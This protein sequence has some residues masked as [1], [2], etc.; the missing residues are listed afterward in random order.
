[1]SL[2]RK[3]L[4]VDDEE[5]TLRGYEAY[6]TPNGGEKRSPRRSSRMAEQ[7]LETELGPREG[8]FEIYVAPSG[9]EA[10]ELFNE[11]FEKGEPIAAGFFDVNLKGALDGLQTI[12]AIRSIDPDVHCVVVTAYQDRSVEEIHKLFGEEFKDQWDYLNKPFSKGEIL[13][14]ARQMIGAWNRK[15]QIRAMHRSLMQSERL[16]GI[17]QVARGVGHEFNNILLRIMGKTD[18]ALREND[19]EKIKEHLKIIMKAT[20]RAR[21]IVNNLQSFSKTKEKMSKSTFSEP[22][23]E[24]L[25]LVNHELVK[26]SVDLRKEDTSHRSIDMDVG[27]I[28]QVVLNLVLNS[29]YALKEGGLIKITISDQEQGGRPGV[30]CEIEDSGEGIPQDV[31]PHVFD[32]AFTTKGDEGS[33]IGL[34][35]SKQIIEA[36]AGEISVESDKSQGTRFSIWLPEAA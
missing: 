18:L 19:A 29:L 35:I 33:G 8:E 34:A 32:F 14:K 20:E 28:A 31:L 5:E 2:N 27:K 22:L 4:V 25:N 10:V 15:H 12:Q 21:L 30:L 16:A 6:L 23:E 17:G 1:M 11:H 3:I 36:H 26:H 7:S 24:A 13:Q 9:E